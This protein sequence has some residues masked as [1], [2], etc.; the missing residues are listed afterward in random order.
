MRV[1]CELPM[2]KTADATG[3][4]AQKVGCHKLAAGGEIAVRAQR[5]A[6]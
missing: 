6:K 3:H 4:A 1:A 5:L 2:G